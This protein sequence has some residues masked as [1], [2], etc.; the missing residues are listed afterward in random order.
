MLRNVL[1]TTIV[2]VAVAAHA[3]DD[4]K[5]ATTAPATTTPA[6]TTTPASAATAPKIDGALKVAAASDLTFAFKDLGAAYEK[7]TGQKVEF[8]FGSTGLLAKQ[9]AEG[10]P[11]DVFAAANVSFIDDVVKAG[12]CDASTKSD[13]AIGRLAMWAPNDPK[14]APP[15]TLNDLTDKRFVK[16]AIANPEHAPYG[17]AAVEAMTAAGIYDAVKSKLVYGENVSQTLQF[18]QSGNAEV[19]M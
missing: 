12:A 15:A 5:K 13:Y 6:T 7:K 3:G 1:A 17:K 11:F 16:I 8:S 9:L 10:A 19:A 14:V 4:S 18:A 2:L